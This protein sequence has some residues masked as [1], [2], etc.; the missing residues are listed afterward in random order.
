MRMIFVKDIVFKPRA[1]SVDIHMG[2]LW[3][4]APTYLER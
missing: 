4:H 3:A 1:Y 2:N